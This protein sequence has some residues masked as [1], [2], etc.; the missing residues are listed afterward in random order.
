[1]DEVFRALAD[2]TRREILDLLFE[3]DGQT[4]GEL[5]ERFSES[6]SRFG[7]MKHL[8]VLEEANLVVGVRSG[9][10][11][12]L[13]LNPV[14]IEQIANRWIGKYAA[15]FTSALVG[16]QQHVERQEHS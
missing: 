13:Y 4:V 15:R 7:V 14:P 5:A 16:L 6:M 12:A 3:R 8:A 2:P 1:M 11:R 9:R 10:T